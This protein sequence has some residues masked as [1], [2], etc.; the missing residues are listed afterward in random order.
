MV[1]ISKPVDSKRRCSLPEDQ[2][3]PGGFWDPS[4]RKE[5]GQA[6]FLRSRKFSGKPK[7]TLSNTPILPSAAAS[8]NAL[9]H[10]RD[11]C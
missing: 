5:P 11:H 3:I 1:A 4:E 7:R 6:S 2:G 10:R 8:G 9:E